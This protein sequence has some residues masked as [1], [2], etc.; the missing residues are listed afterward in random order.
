[1]Y[2]SMW[3][4]ADSFSE[5]STDRHIVSGDMCIRNA[6]VLFESERYKPHTVYISNAAESFSTGLGDVI[7][8]NRNDY[9]VVHESTIEEVYE[10]IQ[11][12]IDLYEEWDL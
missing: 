11:D 7:C 12:T 8:I 5:H 2:L 3:I 6:S 4:L 9:F 1:M 10:K